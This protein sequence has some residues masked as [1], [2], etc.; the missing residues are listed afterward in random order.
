MGGGTNMRIKLSPQRRDDQLV[1]LR[2][3]STLSVNGEVFDFSQMGD[4]DTLPRA[5]I[6]SEWFVGDVDKVAGELTLTLL[7]PNPWNCSPE[8]AFPADLV[9][10][11]DGLVI[12]PQPLPAIEIQAEDQA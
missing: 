8:Q 11:P 5:A 6:Q 9:D 2:S 10:V 12:F 7:L 3:G 4:G 1:V